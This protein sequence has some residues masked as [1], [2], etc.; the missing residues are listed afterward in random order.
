METIYTLTFLLFDLCYNTEWLK[1]KDRMEKGDRIAP[2]QG[3]QDDFSIQR[4]GREARRSLEIL[5]DQLKASGGPRLCLAIKL[6]LLMLRP[7]SVLQAQIGRV[8]I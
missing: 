3:H 8:L 2:T 4:F 1:D 5:D 6:V 7:S